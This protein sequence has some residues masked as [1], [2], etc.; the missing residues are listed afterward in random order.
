M[1]VVTP[2]AVSR[3][4]TNPWPMNP[5]ITAPAN[6]HPM[7]STADPTSAPTTN[8]SSS[9]AATGAASA[10]EPRTE[11]RS[12]ERVETLDTNATGMAAATPAYT[13]NAMSPV[14]TAVKLAIGMAMRSAVLWSNK[15]EAMTPIATAGMR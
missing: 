12:W 6:A 7:A 4:D 5:P 14:D 3:N 11:R 8:T 15:I 1:V 10:A 2:N 13:V 9:A